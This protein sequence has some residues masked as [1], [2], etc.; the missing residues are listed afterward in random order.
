MSCWAMAIAYWASV[1][2]RAFREAAAALKLDSLG[3]LVIKLGTA[4]A[5]LLALVFWGSQDASHDEIVVRLAA[6]GLIFLLF[7]LTYA[8]RIY[9][10]PA[11]MAAEEAAQRAELEARLTPKLVLTFDASVPGCCVKTRFG[12]GVKAT[13]F[14][15]KVEHHGIGIL[16]PCTG[17]LINVTKDGKATDYAESLQ[18][19]WAPA[20]AHDALSKGIA[21]QVPEFLDVCV[22]TEHGKFAL[23]TPWHASISHKPHRMTFHSPKAPNKEHGCKTAAR[24]LVPDIHGGI[25]HS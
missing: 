7:P 10:V 6:G 25:T 3:Q 1:H 24:D 8:Y 23:A 17:R 5:I 22:M 12:T 11:K 18:L 14:R 20:S 4:T 16:Y 21:D 2:R 19:T 15:I 13:F 9:F